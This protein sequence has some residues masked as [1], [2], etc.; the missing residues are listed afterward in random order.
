VN[1]RTK[2]AKSGEWRDN[3]NFFDVAVFGSLAERCAQYLGKGR[4]V[5][6][7]GHLRYREWES[8]GGRRSAVSVVAE[9]V[10][11]IGAREGAAAPANVSDCAASDP[12]DDIPF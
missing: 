7:D 1:D 3:P 11:F 4:Q 6:I 12:D 9:S 2:D 8:D 10:Q 5:A